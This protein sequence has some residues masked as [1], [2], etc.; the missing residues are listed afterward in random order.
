MGVTD[1]AKVFVI[2]CGGKFRKRFNL[3]VGFNRIK[4]N[5]CTRSWAGKVR[6][7]RGQVERA[8]IYTYPFT[9][10]GEE[11]TRCLHH[12]RAM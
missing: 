10:G 6:R 12:A 5:D 11:E 2:I 8:R 4:L 9:W 1:F 3:A 7:G